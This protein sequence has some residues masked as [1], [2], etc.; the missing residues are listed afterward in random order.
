LEDFDMPLRFFVVFL[1]AFLFSCSTTGNVKNSD[2]SSELDIAVAKTAD[3]IIEK[4]PTRTKIALFNI[5]E[6][7]S[8]FTEYVIEELSALLVEKGNFII[9]DRKNRDVIEAEQNFQLSGEVR[10]EDV[11]S[12]GHNYGASSVVT[13]SI[14]GQSDLRRLRVRTIDVETGEVQSL[15]T[16]PIGD[17]ANDPK[18]KTLV[19]EYVIG[20]TGLGGG[21]VFHLEGNAGGMEISRPLSA[22]TW[23]EAKVT[24]ENYRGGGYRDWRLPSLDELYLVYDNLHKSGVNDLGTDFY[25]S[26]TPSYDN[27][28]NALGLGF[29]S[30]N[31]YDDPKTANG[32]VRAVR[33]F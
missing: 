5:S 16:H 32:G 26:S 17:I 18:Y 23:E 12:I 11:R 29:G 27:N 30:G 25:W 6:N 15:T 21:I 1:T 7:E 4:V 19:K 24:A 22:G 13:C 10:D 8:I 2:L 28:A 3:A 20:D 9:V 31:T 14:T 33:S